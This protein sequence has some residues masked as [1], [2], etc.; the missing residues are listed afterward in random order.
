MSENMHALEGEMRQFK[1]EHTKRLDE[2]EVAS[3]GGWVV[4][5]RVMRG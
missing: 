3:K 4:H 5:G 2:L 1:A